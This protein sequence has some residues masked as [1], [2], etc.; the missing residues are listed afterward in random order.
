MN[1]TGIL[2]GKGRFGHKYGHGQREEDVKT[3]GENDHFQAKERIWN[4][5]Q[6][7]PTLLTP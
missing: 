3:Q 1:G 7:E 4:S 2:I 5:P 6:K